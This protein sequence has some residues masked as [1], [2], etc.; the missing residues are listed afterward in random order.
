MQVLWISYFHKLIGEREI[1]IDLKKEKK[2]KTQNPKCQVIIPLSVS[3][4]FSSN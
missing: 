4:P 1:E 3:N 2:K